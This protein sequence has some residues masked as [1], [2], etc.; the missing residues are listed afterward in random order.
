LVVL[1]VVEKS[2]DASIEFTLK[3]NMWMQCELI[4][5]GEFGRL[6]GKPSSNVIL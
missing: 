6:K 1:V 5:D 3:T 2:D 4:V